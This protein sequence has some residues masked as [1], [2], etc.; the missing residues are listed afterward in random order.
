MNSI[1]EHYYPT[2]TMYQALRA[3]LMD[4]LEDADL[5]FTLPG[6]PSLGAL[7]VEIG[8]TE[9]AYIDSFKTF[10]Q[11]FSYRLDDP[12]MAGSVSGLQAWYARLDDDLRASIEALSEDDLKNKV[13]ERGFSVSP[14]IQLTIYNEALLIFYGKASVYLKAMGKTRPEQWVEWIA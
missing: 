10:K 8:E 5:V 1:L 9:Q 14:Q 12:E 6:N 13:I 11:D 3:Q 7:C 4:L 2:F